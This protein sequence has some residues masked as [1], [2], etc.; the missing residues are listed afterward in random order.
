[1]KN[2]NRILLVFNNTK[3]LELLELNLT[4]NGF[5]IQKSG[6]LNDALAKAQKSPP[7]LIVINTSDAEKDVETF[8]KQV[9]MK[10]VKKTVLPSLLELED[11]LTIQT[12]EHVV[13]KGLSRNKTYRDKEFLFLISQRKLS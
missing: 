1:M 12:R 5:E 3:D 6:S 11:Y 13:I 9:N 7:D 2:M 10:Y 8:G 4:R